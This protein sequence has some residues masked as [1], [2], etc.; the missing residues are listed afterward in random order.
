MFARFLLTLA[1]VAAVMTFPATPVAAQEPP[2]ATP[3]ATSAPQGNSTPCPDGNAPQ[4]GT[5]SLAKASVGATILSATQSQQTYQTEVLALRPSPCATRRSLINLIAG[6]DGKQ[7]RGKPGS[8]VNRTGDLR[9]QQLFFLRSAARYASITAD[10][11]HNSSLGMYFQQAIGVGGGRILQPGGSSTAV[12]LDAELR[13][14]H[15]RFYGQHGDDLIGT[16]ISLR[17]STPLKSAMLTVTLSGMPVFNHT[18]AWQAR[19]IIGV[20][21]PLSK[22]FALS[23]TTFDD[24][25]NNVP[26]KYRKNYLKMVVG[27]KFSPPSK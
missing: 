12:E 27:I 14:V 20:A 3:Q 24:Y 15:Q 22:T 17:M 9:L 5:W 19:G 18:D 16:L 11:Y 13:A 7:Q 4:A 6:Y 21:A 2:S 25:I 1:L 23:V 8:T 10:S 26:S